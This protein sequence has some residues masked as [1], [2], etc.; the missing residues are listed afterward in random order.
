[1]QNRINDWISISVQFEKDYKNLNLSQLQIGYVENLKSIKSIDS[2][3]DQENLFKSLQKSLT[4]I[5]SEE[6]SEKERL[7][8]NLL[9]YE[10]KLNLERISLLKKIITL[11]IDSIST[12]GLST[13]ANGKEWYAYFFK[14]WVDIEVTLGI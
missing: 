10:T 11:E 14:K 8:Y 6:L 13:V 1:M 4:Q 7:D 3:I 9:Q 2:I 12:N 5:D